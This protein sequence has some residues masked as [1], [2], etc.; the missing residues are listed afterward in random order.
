[1][2]RPRNPNRD[3]AM[4]KYLA[5]D[6][7]ATIAQLA[8][9]A[10]VPDS[11]VRKWKSADGWAAA[12]E[13]Q[14]SKRKRGAQPGNRNAAGAGAPYGNT[15]AEVHGAYSTVHLEDLPP[16]QRAYIESIELDTRQN[17]LRELQLLIAKEMDLIK[18][19]NALGAESAETLY[20]DKVVEMLVPKGQQDNP[21]KT[22]GE[23]LK[24]AMRTIIKASPFDRALKLEAELNRV[25]GRIIKLVDSIKGYELEA[26]R[27]DVEEK[28]YRLTKQKITGEF[29]IDPQTGEIDDS[30][31]PDDDGPDV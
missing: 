14:R 23:D 28:K 20:V 21:H 31:D 12:L 18:R 10:G 30:K 17:M 16:E 15:N 1:M 9:E 27:L 11:R 4:Q 8:E 25:R 7:K 13:A 26:R 24:T 22:D 6:G 3:E 5:S 2:A 19:I 29:I